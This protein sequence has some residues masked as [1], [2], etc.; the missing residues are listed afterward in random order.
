MLTEE[1]GNH[2]VDG[3]V[4]YMAIKRVSEC[5]QEGRESNK[6]VS[7]LI[8][9]K[10]QHHPGSQNTAFLTHGFTGNWACLDHPHYAPRGKTSV[11]HRSNHGTE[12]RSV[13]WGSW[14]LRKQ[15]HGHLWTAYQQGN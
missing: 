9:T 11:E 7:F 6:W 14:E 5:L 13:Q 12:Q 10:I 1:L 3:C 4:W 15:T 2:P 8:S